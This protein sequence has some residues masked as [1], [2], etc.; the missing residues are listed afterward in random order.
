MGGRT[1]AGRRSKAGATAPAN[2]RARRSLW[3][4]VHRW[5]GLGLGLW[6]LLV[7]LTGALLVWRDAVDALLNPRLFAAGPAPA[8][9]LPLADWIE[10]ARSAH[11]LGRVERV[12]LPLAAG[13]PLRLQF[14]TA[15]VRVESERAEVF[16]DPATGAVLGLRALEGWSLAPPHAL[17]TIYEFHRNVL[18]GEP[19]TNLVGV[20][21]LLLATSAVSGAVLA[22]RRS[23]GGGG[24]RW[25]RLFQVSW[26]AN[27]ARVALDLHRSA[28]VAIVVVLLLATLTGATLV[29]LNYVRDIVD[30][31]SRVESIPVL[32]FRAM[33]RGQELLDLAT[34]AQRAQAAQ[35][36]KAI[37]EIRL[38]ERGLTGVL[39][40]L[41]AEGD[42]HRLGDTIVWLHPATGEVLAE[43]SART[44]SGGETFMHWLLPLHVG[45]AFG[46]GGKVAM[47]AA[48]VAPLLLALTGTW[49]W[50]RKRRAER[51]AE[52]SGGRAGGQHA[53][54][55]A[56]P[57]G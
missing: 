29:W 39:F 50:W 48:G 14:R 7:G 17:R 9:P 36:G 37:S 20:A 28:G 23:G 1:E 32:P 46:T 57:P 42:V 16:V 25:R 44:R 15:A 56:G 8:G 19:G 54:R 6:F 55:A 38:S 11:E 52:R 35:P 2:A 22:W 24:H 41:R 27:A 10:Q 12:R 51:G 30:R 18:L 43:R 45:S 31:V 40:Q 53:G 4:R 13:D 26:R 49:L 34:L 33:A 5:L 47:A 3:A 21:G